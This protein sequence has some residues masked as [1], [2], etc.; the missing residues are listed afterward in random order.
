MLK[1]RN[2]TYSDL[3]IPQIL[4]IFVE[5]KKKDIEKC[6]CKVITHWLLDPFQP[7]FKKN[8][9]FKNYSTIR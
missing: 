6:M 7:I 4:N 9:N 8:F 2:I 5:Q 1:H 3:W